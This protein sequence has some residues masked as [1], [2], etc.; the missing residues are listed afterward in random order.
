MDC[1]KHWFAGM[2]G[3]A[4]THCGGGDGRG[5]KAQPLGELPPPPPSAF[6]GVLEGAVAKVREMMPSMNPLQRMMAQG[7]LADLEEGP[8]APRTGERSGGGG[9]GAAGLEE[10]VMGMLAAMAQD[11]EMLGAIREQAADNPEML[12]SLM[13]AMMGGMP[14]GGSDEEAEDD[15]DDDDEPLAKATGG[16]KKPGSNPGGSKRPPRRGGGGRG[17]GGS[18][19]GDSVAASFAY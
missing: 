18:G 15:D 13:M 19:S 4:C 16:A 12:M 1:G 17:G 11:P 6:D 5:R 10:G 3:F 9:G 2:S 14:G 8:S 7:L